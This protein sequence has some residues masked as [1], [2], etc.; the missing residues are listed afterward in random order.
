M[1]RQFV[2]LAVQMP[3]A[4]IV[5]SVYF[6]VRV[7]VCVCVSHACSASLYAS[8][9]DAKCRH[10]AGVRVHVCARA[11]LCVYASVGVCVLFVTVWLR[12]CACM[13]KTAVRESSLEADYKSLH[14]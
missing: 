14:Q 9:T 12:L 7:C 2:T 11:T 4:D 8:G 3:S 6:Q 1:Q 10:C 13:A 5:R